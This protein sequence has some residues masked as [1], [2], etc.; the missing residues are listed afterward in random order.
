M[1]ALDTPVLLA[2][3]AGEP[4]ALALGRR[5]RGEELATTEMNLLEL[6]E[7]ASRSAR[8]GRASRSAAI[9]RLR[10]RLTVLPIERAAIEEASR[11]QIRGERHENLSI[12]AMLAALEVAGCDEL[13]TDNPTQFSG[14]WRFR[15]T[16]L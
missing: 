3:L 5:W 16:K 15:C 10:R 7:L 9:S 4:K 6:S 12:L 13:V 8:K 2:L 14:T 1:K 11:R